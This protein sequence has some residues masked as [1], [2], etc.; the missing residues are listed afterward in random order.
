M[1]VKLR[2]G[3]FKAL[4]THVP[5]ATWPGLLTWVGEAL[6]RVGV[7]HG[8]VVASARLDQAGDVHW[9]YYTDCE[10]NL[11]HGNRQY[12]IQFVEE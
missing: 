8:R 1:M 5:R 11:L 6:L 7:G 2:E 10:V 12:E 9:K 3:L 4:F